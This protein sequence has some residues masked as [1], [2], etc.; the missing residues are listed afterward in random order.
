MHKH[1][2]ISTSFLPVLFVSCPYETYPSQSFID[3][4][5]VHYRKK[6]I[7]LSKTAPDCFP[8]MFFVPGK[9]E[10]ARATAVTAAKA[11]NRQQCLH[12]VRGNSTFLMLVRYTQQDLF[13]LRFLEKVVNM[14]VEQLVFFEVSRYPG[15][16]TIQS[17]SYIGIVT[18]GKRDPSPFTNGDRLGCMKITDESIDT[19]Y[20]FSHLLVVIRLHR[21][22]H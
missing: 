11:G 22:F 12:V 13:H 21:S 19:F 15:F 20:S 10:M 16:Q 8:E 14:P 1:R 18:G 2:G 6:K 7:P 4:G 5:Y 3:P 17:R 9:K